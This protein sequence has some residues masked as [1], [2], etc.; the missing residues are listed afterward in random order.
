MT[1]DEPQ[2]PP[3]LQVNLNKDELKAENLSRHIPGCVE[4]SYSFEPFRLAVIHNLLKTF[5]MSMRH[6]ICVVIDRSCES[7]AD[8]G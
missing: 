4:N 5:D 1:Y 8:G 3:V 6:E 2:I 7:T